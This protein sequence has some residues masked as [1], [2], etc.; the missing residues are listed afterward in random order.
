MKLLWSGFIAMRKD[1]YF[2][3]ALGANDFGAPPGRLG[4]SDFIRVFKLSGVYD[5]VVS[6]IGFPPGWPTNDIPL[7]FDVVEFLYAEATPE[8]RRQDFRDRLN[9]DLA[10]H[11]PPMEMTATGQIVE[12]GPDE[13]HPL[14]VDPIPE[15]TPGPLADPLQHAIEQYRRRGASD[16]D[17]RTALKQLADVLEPLRDDIDE[18]LLPADE[19]ALFRIANKFYIRHNDREQRRSYD[20]DVWLDWIFYVYVA[21]A[22]ALLAS[23]DRE[24]LRERVMGE[25]PD[26]NGGIP[27]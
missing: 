7:L 11:D 22:R 6:P 16:Q 8:E 9:P 10:L 12:I 14:L 17:K 3:D 2:D 23:L 20:P 4:E 13:L 21:T 18:S 25:P 26:D 27:F 1:G 5:R 19:Q 24:Q 15:G